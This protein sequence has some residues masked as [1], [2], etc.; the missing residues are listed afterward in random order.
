MSVWTS[1]GLPWT[2][3]SR[4]YCSLSFVTPSTTSPSSTVV[5][6]HSGFSRVEETTYFGIELNLSANSP[7]KCGHTG[8]N[9][10]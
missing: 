7:S 8:A 6:F 3:M 1:R 4:S 5:L 9:P 10:S 2:T